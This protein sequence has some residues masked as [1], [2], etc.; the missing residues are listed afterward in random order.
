LTEILPKPLVP[1]ANQPIIAYSLTALAQASIKHVVIN[2]HYKGDLIRQELESG[3]K[4]NLDISYSPEDP[5][6]GTGGGLVNNRDFFADESFLLV[7]GDILCAVDLNQVIEF[8]Q[9]KQAAATM[10]VRPYP[11]DA[12]FTQLE[13]DQEGWLTTF[14]DAKRSPQ[15]ITK[16][17]MFCG[18]HVLEPKIFDFLP[19]QGFSCVNSQGYTGMLSQGLDIAAFEYTGPWYDIGTP[20]SYLA[21][22]RDIASKRSEFSQLPLPAEDILS[23]HVVCAKE[24]RIHANVSLGP[25]VVIGKSAELGQGANISRSVIWPNTTVAPG[26]DL[27]NA[28]LA[29]NLSIQL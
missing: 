23:N 6:L 26:T 20:A 5:I 8:H 2:L 10:V 3:S 25:E 29:G 15:G 16:P 18:V 19:R 21:A 27:D 1:V 24:C 4:Y 7:N 13:M 22:N 14:K 12:T 28:I 11:S 9:R 17:V